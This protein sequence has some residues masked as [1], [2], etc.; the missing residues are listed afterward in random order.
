MLQFEHPA[1]FYALLLI[2]VF[3]GLFLYLVYWKRK[4]MEGFG[5]VAVIR[6]LI[7]DLSMKRNLFKFIVMMSAY[8]LLVLGL[9]NPQTGSKLQEVK[10]SGIDI[11]VALDV[12][13]SMLAEDIQPNRLE[14]AKQAI[15]RLIDK[16][17]EDRIGIVIFAGKAYTQLPITT[18]YGAAK[19]FLSN[20]SNQMVPSQGTAIGDAID[21]CVKSFK[22]STKSKVIILISD[23]ENHEDDAMAAAKAAYENGVR[24]YSIGI[25]SPEGSP[26]PLY[27]EAGVQTGYKADRDGNTIMTRLDETGLQQLASAGSGIYIR[28]SNTEF[29]L[30]K[31][32]DEISK[33]DKT[34]F[35][36]KIYSDYEDRFQYFIGLSLLLIL[37]DVFFFERRSKWVRKL[38]LFENRFLKIK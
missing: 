5:D 27:N 25:G 26:I 22:N 30:K 38:H 20:I 1:Y 2:P 8:A 21:L 15:S 9:A 7:P 18:D 37:L 11:M 17:G 35:E 13:N 6:R 29:G 19:L 31:I 3:T 33:L 16:L 12:S 28:A 23:G 32:F 4:S 14:R 10:R 34:E 24:V 36:T